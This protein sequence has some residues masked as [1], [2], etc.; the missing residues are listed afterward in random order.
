MWIKPR[1]VAQKVEATAKMIRKP[2]SMVDFGEENDFS[3][4]HDEFE[5]TFA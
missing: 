2:A 3:L 1:F 4:R 5:R